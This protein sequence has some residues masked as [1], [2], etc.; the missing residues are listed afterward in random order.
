MC[1]DGHSSPIA[2]PL[3][4]HPRNF[5]PS[6]P[7]AGCTVSQVTAIDTKTVIMAPAGQM[8]T[9]IRFATNTIYDANYD[10]GGCTTQGSKRKA[11]A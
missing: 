2:H 10:T 8:L 7:A 3:Y 9:S 5:D 4:D 1:D 11:H 6:E